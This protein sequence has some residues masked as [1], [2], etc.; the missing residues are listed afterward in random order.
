M[1]GPEGALVR[2]AHWRNFLVKYAEANRMHKKMLALSGLC[3]ER[4]DPPAAR[5][6]IGRAQCNDAYW[7]GVFGGLYLPHL[8]NAIWRNLALAEAELRRGEGLIVEQLDLDGDGAEEVWIHSGVFSALISPQRG[9]V[10]EEYTLLEQGINY[11]DV[12]TRRRESYHE[13]APGRAGQPEATTADGTPSIHALEQMVRLQHLPPIDRFDRAL[14]VD[15]VLA[16]DVTLDHYTGGAFE[17]VACWAG[18]VF[19]ASLEPSAHAVEVVLRP[20][21]DASPPGLLE[22]RIRFDRAGELSVRYRWDPAAFPADALFCPEI[23]VS[24]EMEL[25]LTAA[26]TVWKFPVAT[27]SRSERGFEETVQGYSYTPRW[28][29]RAGEARLT[30]RVRPSA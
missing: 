15:R 13:P 30:L 10:I 26:A 7:H 2:G 8:R 9:G 28:P 16:G 29:I 22:K 27:V 11:A 25:D 19:Q 12:L 6:A 14:F 23:S 1:A 3:R 5:R 20:M 21:P 17:S 4:G 24:R 18:G